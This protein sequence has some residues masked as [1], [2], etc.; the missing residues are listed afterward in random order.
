MSKNIVGFDIDGVVTVNKM[1]YECL[2]REFKG[3]SVEN[4]KFYEIGKTLAYQGFIEKPEDFNDSYFFNKY[5]VPIYTN[6]KPRAGLNEYLKMLYNSGAEVH[7]VTARGKEI[8]ELTYEFFKNNKILTSKSNIHHVGSYDKG[9]VLNALGVKTFIEDRAETLYH[10][11]SNDIIKNGIIVDS[12][13]NKN[14]PKLKNVK[15]IKTFNDL[16]K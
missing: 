10:L 1:M 12:P 9:K 14:M 6:S 7:F 8:E 13:Y 5:A 11:L 4:F 3:F 15:R 2:K 16:L